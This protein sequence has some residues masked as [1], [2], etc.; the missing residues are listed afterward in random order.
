MGL[1]YMSMS[2]FFFF[3]HQ[4][5]NLRPAGDNSFL[6]GSLTKQ[7]LPHGGFKQ[8]LYSRTVPNKPREQDGDPTLHTGKHWAETKLYHRR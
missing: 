4:G 1:H 2:F 6:Y 8:V 3:L 7:H 5:D